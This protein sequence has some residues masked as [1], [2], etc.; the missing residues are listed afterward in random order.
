M[1]IKLNLNKI[2]DYNLQFI[3]ENLFL[4][5]A[6]E[7]EI[8]SSGE[9]DTEDEASIHENNID[10]DN[11]SGM[12]IDSEPE[13]L[14]NDQPMRMADFVWQHDP[15]WKPDITEF[16]VQTTGCNVDQLTGS[17]VELDFFE[18]FFTR[19]FMEKI[20][21]EC[22]RQIVYMKETDGH[23]FVKVL[24]DYLLIKQQKYFQ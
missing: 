22:N 19:E 21:E 16:D 18:I 13:E 15:N 24:I 10:S 2:C 4:E 12:E 11:E 9:S 7:V 3:E 6:D 5:D 23:E 8:F 1:G 14:E 20:T 17:S